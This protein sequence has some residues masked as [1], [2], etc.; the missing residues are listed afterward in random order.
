MATVEALRVMGNGVDV[1]PEEGVLRATRKLRSSGGSIVVSIPPQML[2]AVSFEEDDD[3]LLR[4]EW[5]GDEICL[6]PV[7]DTDPSEEE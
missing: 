5:D 2:Q 7:E 3:I 1:D 6:H 4:C